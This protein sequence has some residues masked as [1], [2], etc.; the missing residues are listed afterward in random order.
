MIL[1]LQHRALSI[2][3]AVSLKRMTGKARQL[4]GKPSIPYLQGLLTP[5]AHRGVHQ[6]AL[7]KQ[8]LDTVHL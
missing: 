1:H 8:G 2:H 4:Q 6:S 3:N 5:A 7:S